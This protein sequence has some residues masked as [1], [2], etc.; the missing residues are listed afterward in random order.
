VPA[1]PWRQG[2]VLPA[3]ERLIAESNIQRFQ[4]ES[5]P[6]MGHLDPLADFPD[7]NSFFE[8]VVPFLRTIVLESPA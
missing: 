8:K 2:G 4:L 5:D 1:S 7:Q 3:A 6:S